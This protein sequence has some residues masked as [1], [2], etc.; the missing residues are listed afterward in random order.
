MASSK[1]AEK[2]GSDL[3]MRALVAIQPATVP[4]S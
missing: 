4:V 1:A 2:R 3:A